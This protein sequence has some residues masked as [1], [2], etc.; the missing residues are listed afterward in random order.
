MKEKKKNQFKI[1]D[2][3]IPPKYE[4]S[5][6]PKLIS[7]ARLDKGGQE[8]MFEFPY[9]K[10]TEL[11]EEPI[12][13]IFFRSDPMNQY[14]GMP[15]SS[16][17]GDL[18]FKEE[19][20]MRSPE[21]LITPHPISLHEAVQLIE[22]DKRA[23]YA[24]VLTTDPMRL[25]PRALSWFASV[26]LYPRS[27]S[28]ESIALE[29]RH[30]E[31]L[32]KIK[33]DPALIKE[34]DTI[35]EEFDP[36]LDCEDYGELPKPLQRKIDAIFAKA[37]KKDEDEF[38]PTLK[39]LSPEQ[40]QDAESKLNK[41]VELSLIIKRGKEDYSRTAYEHKHRVSPDDYE[42]FGLINHLLPL[43]VFKLYAA[44][45]E[46]EFLSVEQIA[47]SRQNLLTCLMRHNEDKVAVTKKYIET[48]E[49]EQLI[50]KD[51]QQ[52]YKRKDSPKVVLYY[53]N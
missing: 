53:S 30:K 12:K 17:P 33:P 5:G 51:D 35:A 42:H 24:L 52:R 23:G 47:C 7:E 50:V 29:R 15:R 2:W 36:Y 34:L 40:I 18:K 1:T 21:E 49:K 25:G 48:L 10:D 44:I 11:I 16:T 19:F 14:G 3:E 27:N 4:L 8:R 26:P 13:P 46:H 28:L 39:E 38:G 22:A 43:G 41:L 45:P 37:H 9:R 20:T 31:I 6:L 32:K